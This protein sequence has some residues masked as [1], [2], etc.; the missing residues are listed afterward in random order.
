MQEILADVDAW[1]A[2]N[3]RIALAT[4]I[5]T[6]GS[7]PRRVGAKMAVNQKKEMTG[8]VS[9]G[10]VEGAVI[11]EANR[12]IKTGRSE[13]LHFGVA[14]E[15]AWEVG[16]AC[17]GSIEVFV[18]PLAEELFPLWK[19]YILKDQEVIMASIVQGP[20]DLLR[21]KALIPAKGDPVG[22][23]LQTPIG[24]KVRQDAYQFLQY[25]TTSTIQRYKSLEVDVFFDVHLSAPRLIIVGG[26][27]LAIALAHFARALGFRTYLVDPR[28]AFATKE[29]FPQVEHIINKWPDEALLEIGLTRDASVVVVTHDPKLDDPALMV[30]LPSPARYVG[31]LGSTRTHALRVERL[32]KAGLLQAHLDRLHAPIGLNIGG[33]SP[34]E[35]ALSIIAEIVAV[36]NDKAIG[37]KNE[38]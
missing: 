11:E 23:L 28:T 2:R 37:Q 9:G 7:S 36:R 12:V 3:D 29:R 31:A 27:H 26:V 14:D 15:E 19:D 34:A 18:E 4:V 30:A 13:L 5:K 1:R 32:L 17:G 38:L 8:S 24:E 22:P 10:C 35:I 33:R 6:W 21:A 20:D 16:L 25:E